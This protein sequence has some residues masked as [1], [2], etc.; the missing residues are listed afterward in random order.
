MM[1]YLLFDPTLYANIKAEIAPAVTAGVQGLD[2]RLGECP[3]LMALYNEILR[4][5]TASASVR[6]VE[7]DT[8]VRD[9]IL[10]KGGKVLLPFR[11]LHFNEKVFGSDVNRFDPAR[12]LKDQKLQKNSSFRPFG[13][14]TTYCPG[15]YLA[16]REVLVFIALSMFRFES[17]NL[18]AEGQQ[19][20]PVLDTKKPC[21][22]IMTP[23]AGQDVEVVIRMAETDKAPGTNG[24]A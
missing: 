10:R 18:A 24:I 17:L 8:P 21:L 12:F 1:A 11:Q 13:G 22:G 20:F 23:V 6:T 7:S 2:S 3:R 16:Q 5:T 19:A 14:G 9:V 15:R 4:L